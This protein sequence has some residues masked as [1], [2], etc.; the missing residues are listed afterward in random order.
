MFDRLS[1]KKIYIVMFCILV[2]RFL[3]KIPT[4]WSYIGIALLVLDFILDWVYDNKIKNKGVFSFKGKIYNIETLSVPSSVNEGE[5]RVKVPT[6]MKT[7]LNGWK[8]QHII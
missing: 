5:E 8:F 2:S 7:V 1:T 6:H 4:Y 3:F